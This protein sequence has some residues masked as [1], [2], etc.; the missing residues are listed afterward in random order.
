MFKGCGESESNCFCAPWNNKPRKESGS[1]SWVLCRRISAS[2]S[3]SAACP[4]QIPE[5]SSATASAPRPFCRSLHSQSLSMQHLSSNA[6]ILQVLPLLLPL[7]PSPSPCLLFLPLPL[8]PPP[9]PCP[10]PPLPPSTSS[11]PHCLV[12]PTTVHL[13]SFPAAARGQLRP[14]IESFWKR[15]GPGKLLRKW[16]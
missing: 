1:S 11:S 14:H 6:L 13:L 7:L 2:F 12:T 5:Y 4:P 8:C 16:Q 3:T 10:P 9:P 15:P